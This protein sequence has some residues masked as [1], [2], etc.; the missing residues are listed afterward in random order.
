MNTVWTR[1]I[2][3]TEVPSPGT[4]TV[5]LGGHKILVCRAGD[6]VYAVE[7][8]CT[9]DDGVLGEG[10][11]NGFAVMCPRHGAKFDIRTG[12]VLRMPAAVPVRTYPA[13]VEGPDI[14]VDLAG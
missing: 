11:L 14:L 10:E 8:R 9:H 4:K 6:T 13:K 7:D 3:L 12:E 5:E 2:A 1:A